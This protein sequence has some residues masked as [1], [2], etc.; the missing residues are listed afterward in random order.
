M[1]QIRYP[2]FASPSSSTLLGALRVLGQSRSST[3][4]LLPGVT[5]A[6][7][8]RNP[9]SKWKAG[10]EGKGLPDTPPVESP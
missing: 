6:L 7:T 5:P 2:H 9:D 8:N 1:P 3:C 10:S 4:P